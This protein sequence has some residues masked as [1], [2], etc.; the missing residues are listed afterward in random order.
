MLRFLRHADGISSFI[1]Q[2]V[3]RKKKGGK[4]MQTTLSEVAILDIGSA[5]T[6]FVGVIVI[7]AALLALGAVLMAKLDH[8]P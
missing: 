7:G 5:A 1:L 8:K 3:S 6:K 4:M 2:Y